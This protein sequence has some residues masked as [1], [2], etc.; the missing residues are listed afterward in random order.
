M[1]TLV[2]ICKAEVNCH[3]HST[4]SIIGD[5][6]PDPVDSIEDAYGGSC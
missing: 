1:L 6:I 5:H 4:D 3:E 2:H